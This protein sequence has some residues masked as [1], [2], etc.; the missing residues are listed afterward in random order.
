MA[1]QVLLGHYPRSLPC[2]KLRSPL[3]LRQLADL[4]SLNH[5]NQHRVVTVLTERCCQIYPLPLPI[6]TLSD[7]LL[8]LRLYSLPRT[9]ERQA[10]HSPVATYHHLWTPC[11]HSKYT[12]FWRKRCNSLPIVYLPQCLR[13]VHMPLIRANRGTILHPLS[14]PT[15]LLPS[16]NLLTFRTLALTIHHHRVYLD[17]S[18][19]HR[20]QCS[21]QCLLSK[22]DVPVVEDE[23]N[24]GEGECPLSS[25]VRTSPAAASTT[26]NPKSTI[27]GKKYANKFS[28]ASGKVGK[29]GRQKSL[30]TLFD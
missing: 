21:S 14:R 11:K 27:A 4:S 20:P 22:S 19:L 23:V 5:F 10:R 29:K 9:K 2:P 18:Y 6:L 3:Y 24:L 26:P 15:L 16:T 8:I 12:T 13:T 1:F 7:I 17:L 30:T 28:E 25:I